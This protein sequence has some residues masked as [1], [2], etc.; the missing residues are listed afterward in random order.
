MTEHK[1]VTKWIAVMSL[2]AGKPPKVTAFSIPVL[3]RPGSYFYQSERT[4][5]WGIEAA[6]G[7]VHTF[8]KKKQKTLFDTKDQAL[9]ALLDL[10]NED[11][12]VQRNR[13][14]YLVAQRDAVLSLIN[15]NVEQ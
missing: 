11:L 3:D 14:I 15:G 5:M 10:K 1:T 6:L 7:Y 4:H 2:V 13:T 9:Y 8:P 12:A